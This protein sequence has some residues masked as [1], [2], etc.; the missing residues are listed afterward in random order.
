MANTHSHLTWEEVNRLLRRVSAAYGVELAIVIT[1]SGTK[2]D[3]W[4]CDC[5]ASVLPIMADG[6]YVNWW[7]HQDVYRARREGGLNRYD[8]LA[9]LAYWTIDDVNVQLWTAQEQQELPLD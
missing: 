8:S 3:Q 1:T 4:S 7:T 2:P 5:V 9:S 6:V